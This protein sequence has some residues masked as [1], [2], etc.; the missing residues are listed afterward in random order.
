MYKN[1]DGSTS[2]FCDCYMENSEDKDK[3]LKSEVI[4]RKKSRAEINV[5]FAQLT[6]L[7]NK[8]LNCLKNNEP[9]INFLMNVSPCDS[10]NESLKVTFLVRKKDLMKAKWYGIPKKEIVV[11]YQELLGS[12]MMSLWV[13]ENEDMFKSVTYI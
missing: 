9:T 13:R 12:F 4:I 2:F 7:L 10:D 8:K 11:I 3:F 1:E 5:M 6:M